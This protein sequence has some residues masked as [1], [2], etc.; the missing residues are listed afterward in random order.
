[1]GRVLKQNKVL[2]NTLK[3]VDEG[4]G[5]TEKLTIIT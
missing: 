3:D 5:S 1:M 4:G 2:K